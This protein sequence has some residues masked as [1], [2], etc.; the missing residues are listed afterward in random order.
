MNRKLKIFCL[1]FTYC[2]KIF[3]DILFD[4]N[5]QDCKNSTSEN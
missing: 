5:K 2:T 4:Q 1:N 3:T